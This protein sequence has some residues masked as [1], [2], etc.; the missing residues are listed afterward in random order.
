MCIIAACPPGTTPDERD[1]DV[2]CSNN[3]DGFGWA[4]ATRTRMIT[5]RT[6]SA[7][8]AMDTF[9]TIRGQCPKSPALFHARIATHSAVNLAGCHPFPIGDDR[10]MMA[11]NGILYQCEPGPYDPRSD[12]AVL[13]EDIIPRNGG[14][15]SIVAHR[16]KWGEWIGKNNKLVFVSSVPG[17]QKLTIVNEQAG[18]W[19]GGI[20]WSNS[21]YIY[22]WQT[23]KRQPIVG[24]SH[25]W[26]K[27]GLCLSYGMVHEV[28]GMD[29]C[30]TCRG[31]LGYVASVDPLDLQYCDA[32]GCQ[33]PTRDLMEY[34]GEV[35]CAD[36][37][38]SIMTSIGGK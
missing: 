32:C 22:D 8:E 5:H 30:G 14:I 31:Q 16:D 23:W 24:S 12:S 11:H 34:R 25:V 38:H 6:M 37:D 26:A 17:V 19:D 9:L 20:W 4:I 21:G 36:C 13:A 2:A 35:I 29:L 28:E 7:N 10:T 3:P 27:C 18:E 33:T 1:L 15:A